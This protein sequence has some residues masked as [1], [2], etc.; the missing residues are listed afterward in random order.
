MIF[1]RSVN[2]YVTRY[3]LQTKTIHYLVWMM[4]ISL[5]QYVQ[6]KHNFKQKNLSFINTPCI[7]KY[8]KLHENYVIRAHTH[9]LNTWYLILN[10]S[11]S[12]G[13]P[14]QNKQI[15]YTAAMIST[16]ELWVL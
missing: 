8:I 5:H 15:A 16:C 4:S 14:V 10:V 13:L 6:L 1:I 11:V 9:F 2:A 7:N 3:R 12:N